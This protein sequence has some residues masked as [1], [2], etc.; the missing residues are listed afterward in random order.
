MKKRCFLLTTFIVLFSSVLSIAQD[1]SETN[2]WTKGWTNF[3]PNKTEYPKA[4]ENL[5]NIIVNT[6]YLK[7]DVVYLMSGD[8]YVTNGASL[9][10]EEGTIIRC[11]HVNPANLIVTKGSKLVATGSMAYP[12]VFTSNKDAKS[13]KS[14]DWGGIII[15]GSGKVNTATGNGII[16]GDFKPEFSVYGGNQDFEETTV[17][18]YVRIEFSGNTIKRKTGSSGLSLYGLGTSSTLENI[19]ISHAGQD[20]FNIHGG[21]NDFQNLVSLKS[22]GN[23]YHIS[24][25]FKGDLNNI[26]AIRH[27]YIT[28]SQ[29]SYAIAIDGYNKD[30]GAMKPSDA[31]DIT[32]SNATLVNL[33]DKSNYQHTTS[34]VSASNLAMT[35]IH[36]SK[37]SGFSDVVKF[38]ESYTSLLKIQKAFMMDNSFFNIHGEGVDVDNEAISKG[39]LN[40]LKYNR[41]TE[42]FTAVNDLFSDPLS[43]VFPKFKLKQA[44]NNYTVM[45]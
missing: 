10:I 37:I 44:L 33:S 22:H 43:S 25:G 8:V 42:G 23:D 26:I 29:A 41:F 18:K 2:K 9:I 15:A 35:Y 14:G 45:Q 13:R 38:D 30:L 1:F 3:S 34:A 6:M 16:E 4:E 21:K 20:S 17:L 36:N 31:T 27:P 7:N 19:M 12:I 24:Q 39:A 32:I 5:P 11:D 28:S 40:V